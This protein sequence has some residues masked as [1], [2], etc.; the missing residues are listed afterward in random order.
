MD[1]SRGDSFVMYFHFSFCEDHTV[2]MAGDYDVIAFDLPLDAGILAQNKSVRGNQQSLY[3]SFHAEGSRTLQRSLE[4][5]RLVEKTGPF[6][7]S[8]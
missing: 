7:M 8:S 4:T 3:I 2:E 6:R 5:N 1:F